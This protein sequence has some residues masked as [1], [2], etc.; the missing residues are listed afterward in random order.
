MGERELKEMFQVIE[1]VLDEAAV[2]LRGLKEEMEGLE[3]S[4]MYPAVPTEQWQS[5]NGSGRR[6]LYMLFR[7]SRAMGGYSGPGG[8]R[9][10]Y[11][12][13]KEER[14]AE[15]RRLVEN[16][17]RWEE[18]EKEVRRVEWWVTGFRRDLKKLVGRAGTLRERLG[19]PGSEISS[20]WSPKVLAGSG[21]V[22][23]ETQGGECGE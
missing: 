11:V 6:Y 9:K 15:A 21:R 3:K 16:R 18:V 19:R 22:G 7:Y 17:L 10:V 12:G 8:K 2:R 14:I 13:C 1:G 20:R 23:D 4:G 5:R